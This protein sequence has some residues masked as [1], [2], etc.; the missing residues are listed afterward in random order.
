MY[1]G[2]DV[3]FVDCAFFQFRDFFELLCIDDLD[4]DLLFGFHMYSFIN[5]TIDSLSELLEY[6]VIFDDF[7]HE[8]ID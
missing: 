8:R 2:E 5:F 3:D 7:T 4:G 6:G 1:G